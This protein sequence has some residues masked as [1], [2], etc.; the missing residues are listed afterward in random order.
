MVHTVAE[1]S[2]VRDNRKELVPM[3][4]YLLD[5][6]VTLAKNVGFDVH[7]PTGFPKT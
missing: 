2:R 4:D 5:P 1:F 7:G 3:W 6:I